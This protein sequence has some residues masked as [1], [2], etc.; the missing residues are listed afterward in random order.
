VDKKVLEKKGI[1]LQ[2]LTTYPVW[3]FDTVL[4]Y[5]FVFALMRVFSLLKLLPKCGNKMDSDK[6]MV[7]GKKAKWPWPN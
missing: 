4:F 1:V 5:L 3:F 6:L 7:K 2:T